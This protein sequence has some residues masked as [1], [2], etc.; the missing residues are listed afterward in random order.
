[1]VAGGGASAPPPFFVWITDVIRSGIFAAVLAGEKETA[2][3]LRSNPL[4]SRIRA[5]RD[6]LIESIPHWL[7]AG[8]TPLHLAAA[9]LR[10]GTIELLIEA[11]ADPNA[12]NRRGATPL[13]YACDPR[14]TS[15]TWN[16][17]TQAAVIEFLASH[18]A[19]LNHA[20]RGGAVPLHRAVRARSAAAVRQLLVLG[21][22]TGRCLRAGRSSPLHLA[23]QSTGASG[24][25]G[26][27]D[28]QVEIIDLLRRHGADV[29]ALDAAGRT[30]QAWARNERV[31]GALLANARPTRRRAR[32]PRRLR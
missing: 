5:P 23:A 11:G 29:A 12:E 22:S 15:H 4:A 18:G 27:V 9:A 10:L 21:A 24:T 14:P 2:R 28:E 3:A 7:Y 8:D 6:V 16:T 13:H 31:A 20:D 17:V 26:T 30:P 32:P 1:M 25:A 19:D